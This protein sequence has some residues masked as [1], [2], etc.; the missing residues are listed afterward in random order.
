MTRLLTI[1][2]VGAACAACPAPYAVENYCQQQVVRQCQFW[3]R[4][5]NTAE[6]MRLGLTAVFLHS[7]E[8]E[9]REMIPRWMCGAAAPAED[10]VA[11]ERA[12]WD[13]A[14]AQECQQHLDD[15]VAVCAVEQ[16]LDGTSTEC[17]TAALLEGQV[18]NGGECFIEEECADADARCVEP[19]SDE[20]DRE[21]VTA[22]GTCEPLPGDGEPCDDS[23]CA[24]GNYCDGTTCHRLLD[25][26][27]TCTSDAQCRSG[28]CDISAATDV[29]AP[30][31]PDGVYCWSDLQCESGECSDV[32]STC[33]SSGSPEGVE[34]DLCTGADR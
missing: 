19:V 29:C 25:P 13:E 16:Y 10:A 28:S 33:G 8:E 3:Y 23:Q 9:C 1:A 34:Y 21:L 4:C 32:T 30:L 7:N 17:S 31:L 27:E 11:E 6:R 12:R 24:E 20:P 18:G 14:K 15:A 22:K 26:G 5:C 2:L